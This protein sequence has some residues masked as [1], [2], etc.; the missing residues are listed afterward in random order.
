MSSSTQTVERFS[1][2]PFEQW[3]TA[4][5]SL[6]LDDIGISTD[7]A[8]GYRE[9][10]L[11]V[12]KAD[13]LAVRAGQ[14]PGNIWEEW[15]DVPWVPDDEY[16]KSGKRYVKSKICSTCKRERKRREFGNRASSSDGLTSECRECNRERARRNAENR[17]QDEEYDD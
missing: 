13:E 15:W 5:A 10:G 1:F 11:S 2:A 9:R 14:H 6:R 3:V 7:I 12:S 4:Q 17:I 16:A 8:R